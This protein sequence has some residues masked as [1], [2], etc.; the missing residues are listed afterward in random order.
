MSSIFLVS[1]SKKRGITCGKKGSIDDNL[2][3]AD[4]YGMN[5]DENDVAEMHA[6]ACSYWIIW[7]LADPLLWK[8]LQQ[9]PKNCYNDFLYKKNESF[10]WD[11]REYMLDVLSE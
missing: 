7:D 2:S 1:N 11:L 10:C 4:Y 3:D 8:S 6:A 9:W 5:C